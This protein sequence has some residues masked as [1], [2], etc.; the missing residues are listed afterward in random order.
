[1]SQASP[2]YYYSDFRNVGMTTTQCVECDKHFCDEH[3]KAHHWLAS[4]A[5]TSAVF[6]AY[7][8][9][10]DDEDDKDNVLRSDLAA[11]PTICH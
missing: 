11:R 2:K 4:P 5:M 10:G 1:M 9:D 8:D 7:H 6:A 3:M